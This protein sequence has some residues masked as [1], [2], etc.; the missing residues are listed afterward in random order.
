MILAAGRGERLRPITDSLPK[1]L[2]PVAGKP[3]L[4]RHLEQLAAAGLREVVIN[5]SWLGAQIIQVVGDGRQFGLRVRYSDEGEHALE[6]GGGIQRALALLGPEPFLVINGDVLCDFPLQG[7]SL[8]VA[9][10]AHLVMVRNPAH[11]PK[12]DFSLRDGQIGNGGERLTFSGL[13]VY[14]PGFFAGYQP[15]KF[16][17]APLL[18][19]AADNGL[20]SGEQWSGFWSDLGT[21]D[22]YRQAERQFCQQ[23]S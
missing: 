7:L 10:Q 18:R 5:V 16:S 21:P 14:D 23:S 6:T 22:R 20:I 8:P 1:P 9:R 4:F 11:N 15:G 19:V 12:G 2:I 17:L 3:L 13:G